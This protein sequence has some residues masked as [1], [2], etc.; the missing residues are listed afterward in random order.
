MGPEWWYVYSCDHMA[1]G[2]LRL[3]TTAK[4][5][6]SPMYNFCILGFPN[7]FFLAGPS[8]SCDSS[9]VYVHS[10]PVG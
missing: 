5:E 9:N 4:D 10:A 7:P 8:L 3:V 2:E 1:D 6:Q